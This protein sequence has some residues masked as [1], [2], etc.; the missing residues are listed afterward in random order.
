[1]KNEIFFSFVFLVI[2]YFVFTGKVAVE[3]M[4]T[5]DIILSVIVLTGSF[6]V[7]ISG[8]G[9][10]KQINKKSK[11]EKISLIFI[12]FSSSLFLVTGITFIIMLILR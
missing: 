10:I 8:I 3:Q 12:L 9:E 11:K 5:S 2:A 1:M 6:F 7:L 4:T